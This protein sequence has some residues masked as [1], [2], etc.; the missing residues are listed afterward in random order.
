[1]K[2]ICGNFTFNQFFRD[3]SV[4]IK[5]PDSY[6]Q[7]FEKFMAFAGFN[8]RLDNLHCG[9]EAEEDWTVWCVKAI[10]QYLGCIA[11]VLE[12]CRGEQ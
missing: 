10:V 5:D 11:K 3:L 8:L 9:A 6:V 7:T 12:E 1:M 4:H 2:K